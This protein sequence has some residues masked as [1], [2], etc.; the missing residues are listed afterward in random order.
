MNA[1]L[2]T[3]KDNILIHGNE[4]EIYHNTFIR[5]MGEYDLALLCALRY[6]N[7]EGFLEHINDDGSVEQH[8]IEHIHVIDLTGNQVI[9]E[10]CL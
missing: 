8:I 7:A 6:L 10:E 2:T 5:T 4:M 9:R 1:G 3:F